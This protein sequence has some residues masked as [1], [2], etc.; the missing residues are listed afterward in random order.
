MKKLTIYLL[1]AALLITLTGTFSLASSEKELVLV[2]DPAG[3]GT[4]TLN[5]LKINWGTS[6]LYALYD[7]LVEMGL[8]GKYYPSLASSWEMSEDALTLIFYLKE[9][10]KF[11]DGSE[12]N[13]DIVKWFI[14]EMRKSPSDYMVQSIKSVTVEDH[15]TV[16]FHME[17]PDPNLLYN[18]SSVFM[19]IPSKEAIEKYGDDFG[20]KYAV[21][22]GPFMLDEWI[23]GDRVVVKK[24]PDYRWG[25]ELSEN[26]GPAKIDKLVIREMAEEVTIFME[27]KSGGV[28]ITEGVPD[29]YLEKI[30]EDKNIDVV[31]IPGSRLYYLAMNTQIE[32]YTDIKVRKAICLAINQEEIVEN[33]FMNVGKPAHTYLVDQLEESKVPEEYKIS[34]NLD[35]AKEIMDEAGW[36]D[37]DGDGILEKGGDKFVANLWIENTSVFRKVAEVAQEQ[38]RKLGIDA[39]ITQYDSITFTDKLKKG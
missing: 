13:A 38:L 26:K 20:I 16:T 34:F 8:D 11:H 39:K 17:Y 25:T 35:K 6:A 15:Y 12:F 23:M 37:T 24:N 33:V 22:T 32:P 10:V 36:K 2:V 1:L 21:G 4:A 28:D 14:E 5:P 30:K 29:I 19:K 7:N 31:G 9:G 3:K 27:L 18:L